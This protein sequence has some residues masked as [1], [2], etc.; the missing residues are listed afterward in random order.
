MRL[1][2][3]EDQIHFIIKEAEK[4]HPIEV[5][6]ALFGKLNGNEARVKKI[7][8]LKN[9]LRSETRFKIDPEEFLEAF[10][11]AEA[12]G[13]RH[14]GFFHSHIS[15]PHPSPRDLE[16][17][18]MWPETIWLIVSALNYEL[19]AYRMVDGKLQ[20]VSISDDNPHSSQL[21]SNIEKQ[22]K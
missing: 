13:L 16:G 22:K 6:G 19:A 12:E 9:I 21:D 7:V 4:K 1:K 3:T 11:K 10:F 2:L 5:C 15:S 17:M 14:L 20:E 18:K 8:V